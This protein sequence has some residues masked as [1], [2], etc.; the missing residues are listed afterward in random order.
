M[1]GEW[2]MFSDKDREW[3]GIRGENGIG[4]GVE[5]GSGE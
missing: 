3:S 1:T 4:L 2:N 5:L